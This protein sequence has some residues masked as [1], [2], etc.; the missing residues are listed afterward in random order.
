MTNIIHAG[1]S[2]IATNNAIF[3]L[4]KGRINARSKILDFGA[5]KGHMSSRI[6]EHYREQG[7]EPK[8]HVVVCDIFPEFYEYPHLT[9]QKVG[10]DCT[11]PFKDKTFDLIYAIEVLEHTPRPYDFMEETFKKLKKVGDFSIQTYLGTMSVNV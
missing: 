6:G 7:H 2:H 10:T 4:I 5:G 11:I 1:G 3:D 8:D 9:C